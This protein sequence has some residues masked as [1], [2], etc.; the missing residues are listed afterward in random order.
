MGAETMQLLTFEQAVRR[1]EQIALPL[2]PA[3][4]HPGYVAADAV[5]NPLLQPAYLSYEDQGEYWLNCFHLTDVPD[6]QWKDASS[7]MA[8]RAP[9][10]AAMLLNSS[11]PPGV[12]TRHGCTVKRWWSSTSGSTRCWETSVTT[13]AAW[14][15]TAR[16]F[17]SIWTRRPLRRH[18]CRQVA[19]DRQESGGRGPGVRGDL[20]GGLRRRVRG[21][22][23]GCHAR[24]AADPFFLFDDDTFI[25]WPRQVWRN[26]A[27][28][29][30]AAV[31][32][33]IGLRRRCF[34]ME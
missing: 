33:V 23:P 9:C 13:A 7:P 15:T 8:T 25:G 5:R 6:T 10:A 14:S 28:A 32:A 30:S 21:I 24:D 19:P 4:L 18:L 3:T 22:S 16:W 1:Y 26:W 20:P 27:C 34:W 17:A 11:R 31:P 2:R 12:P 29:A